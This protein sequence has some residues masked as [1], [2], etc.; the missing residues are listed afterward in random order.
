[1]WLVRSLEQSGT[2]SS[3]SSLSSLPSSEI[4]NDEICPFGNNQSPNKTFTCYQGIIQTTQRDRVT[5]P[6]FP[7]VYILKKFSM[8]NPAPLCPAPASDDLSW[9]QTVWACLGGDVTHREGLD[10]GWTHSLT[11]SLSGSLTSSLT[12]SFT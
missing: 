8:Y 6:V 5:T 4:L 11:S 10:T 1:M 12:S 3:L 9:L 7:Y 2:L